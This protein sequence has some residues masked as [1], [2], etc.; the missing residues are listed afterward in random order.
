MPRRHGQNAGGPGRWGFGD[1]DG[2]KS[3]AYEEAAEQTG[4]NNRAAA[5]Q[6]ME[7]ME[8]CEAEAEGGCHFHWLADESVYDEVQEVLESG[9]PD[10]RSQK[11]AGNERKLRAASEDAL[12]ESG[13]KADCEE[14]YRRFIGL[15]FTYTWKEIQ[16]RNGYILHDLHLDDIPVEMITTDSSQAGVNAEKRSE[17]VVRS[18]KISGIRE[19][20]T[21]GYCFG[22][23]NTGGKKPRGNNYEE[24]GV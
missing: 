10:G 22:E 6:W 24:N 5:K 18:R 7:L 17:A 1:K 4:D 13:C 2:K 19:M 14:T 9:E 21:G 12:E 3:D 15:R 8:A 16:A 11:S 20:G 23:K